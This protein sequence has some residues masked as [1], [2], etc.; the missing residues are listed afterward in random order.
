VSKAKKEGEELEAKAC[1]TDRTVEGEALMAQKNLQ[2]SS[3]EKRKMVEPKDPDIA[4]YRQCEL[5][6]FPGHRTITKLEERATITST[7]EADGRAIYECTLWLKS[8][9]YEVNRKRLKRLI[10]LI[11]IEAIYPRKRGLSTSS[12]G[13]WPLQNPIRS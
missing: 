6:R 4:I 13:V 10:R 1:P 8:Q 7:F 5:V 9:G 2:C 11:G 3:S 12:G